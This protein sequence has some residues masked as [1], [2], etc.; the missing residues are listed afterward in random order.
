MA[1][2]SQT[3]SVEKQI[4]E[5]RQTI[6]EHDHRYYV[7][8]APVIADVEYDALMK[9]LQALEAE[10]PDLITADSVTQRVSGKVAAGFDEYLH[11]RAMLSLDNSYSIDDLRDWAKRCDKLAEGRAF[12]YV[13]ELKIDGLS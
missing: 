8:S 2:P 7:L 12:D 3:Q 4:L 6:N 11:K 10:R 13:A 5:L 1:E 9:R